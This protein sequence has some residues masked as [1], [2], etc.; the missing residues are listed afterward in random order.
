MNTD[1][2]PSDGGQIDVEQLIA[3]INALKPSKR[4]Q[5]VLMFRQMYAAIEKSL[6]RNV[7]QKELLASCVH[8]GLHISLGGFRALLLAERKR[9]EAGED[10]ILHRPAKK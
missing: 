8:H 2:I 5:N 1:M 10:E 9:R 7:T 3:D 4:H 6:E